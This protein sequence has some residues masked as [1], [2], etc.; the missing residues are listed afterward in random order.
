M[1]SMH[2]HYLNK[3]PDGSVECS[4]DRLDVYDSK[5]RHCVAL[6]RDGAGGLQDKSGE[7]GL[8]HVHDMSP[9]P[10]DA[11][12]FKMR[13]GKLAKDEKFEQRSKVVLDFVEDGRVL[14]CEQLADKGMRFD[15]DH[16][17][18]SK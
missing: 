6:R 4:D 16:S 10:K 18:M 7:F 8:P 11:R 12:L 14:S 17:L 15:R 9:I 5:G 13:D 1:K 2:V 3:Y